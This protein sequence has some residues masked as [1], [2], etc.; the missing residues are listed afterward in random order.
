MAPVI[1]DTTMESLPIIDLALA[2]DPATKPQ[3]LEDLKNAL[4]RIGFLYLVNHG[5]EKEARALQKFSPK[6]FTDLS[7]QEKESI[8]MLNNPHFIGYTA[9]GSETTAAK[10]DQR[11]QFDFGSY[12]KESSWKEGDEPYKRLDGPN[13]FPEGKTGE[14][15]KQAVTAYLDAMKEMNF[16]FLQLVAECLNLP[17]NSVTDFLGEMDR[18]KLIRYPPGDGQGVGPHKDSSGMFTYVLQDQTG[19]LQVLNSEGKWIDATPI[20]DSL[21]CNIAQGFEALT[22]GHCGA[23][24]HQVQSQ[25]KERHSIAYFCGVRLDLTREAVQEQCRFIKDKIPSPQD[26]RKREVDVASEFI[27]EKYSCF[28]E[29]HLRNRIVSHRDVG[30]KWYPDLYDKYISDY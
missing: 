1:D 2:Q 24:T 16:K 22:D 19:G 11:E 18:L 30:K 15:M 28:G 25:P 8:A 14:E 5:V 27:S 3:L 9:L 7:H 20:Q 23:T 12:G 26:A 29:A 6:A 21:V 17:K 13:R 10:T 4:F